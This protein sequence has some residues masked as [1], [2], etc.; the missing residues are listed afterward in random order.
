MEKLIENPFNVLTSQNRDDII[1]I[2]SAV[3]KAVES[4]SVSVKDTERAL[5][6]IDETIEMLD[7]MISQTTEFSNKKKILEKELGIF[8]TKQLK[9]MENNLDK[10]ENNKTDAEEKIKKLESEISNIKKSIPHILM[11]IETKL[12]STSATKY[13]IKV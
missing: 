7:N 9:H 13:S 2:L 8:D 6:H 1:K 5:N 11:D 4:G 12:R 3:R 10:A